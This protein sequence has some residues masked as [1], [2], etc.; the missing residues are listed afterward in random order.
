[1][2]IA[3]AEVNGPVRPGLAPGIRRVFLRWQ[4]ALGVVAWSSLIFAML[5]SIC[6]FFAAVDGVRTAIGIG[7]LVLANDT[8]KLID[9]FHCDW[10]RSLMLGIA[11]GGSVLNLLVLWRVRR[12]RNNPAA[13]WRQRPVS[14]GK[15]RMEWVQIGMAVLTLVLVA[16][17]E[18]QHL[19]WSGHL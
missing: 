14:P 4:A 7:A 18:K 9:G 8:L 2:P 1:M 13:R 15:L 10:L 12:L 3:F 16:V 17:E 11:V 6:T 5:Q 19:I